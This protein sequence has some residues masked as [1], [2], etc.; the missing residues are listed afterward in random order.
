MACDECA[1]I[2]EQARR[3]QALATET[4]RLVEVFVAALRV[5]L[6]PDDDG[7]Q[8]PCAVSKHDEPQG[9]NATQGDTRAA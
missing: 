5:R 3:D 7:P 8:S 2:R 9:E 6:T 4:L 1:E